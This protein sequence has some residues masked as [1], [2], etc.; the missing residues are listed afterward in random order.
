MCPLSQWF[1]PSH[2][3]L[4]FK[5]LTSLANGVELGIKE[6]F[7]APLQPLVADNIEAMQTFLGVLGAPPPPPPPP[8]LP[9]EV[10]GAAVA[11]ARGEGG[12]GAVGGGG[13]AHGGAEGGGGAEA[14]GE[15]AGAAG[16]AAGGEAG[17][18]AGG[19]E[20]EEEE[21]DPV[22]NEPALLAALALVQATTPPQPSF[23]WCASLRRSSQWCPPLPP[24]LQAVLVRTTT[25]VRLA[26]SDAA[27]VAPEMEELLRDSSQAETAT[28]AG[29]DG[30]GSLG[31]GSRK[32]K[33]APK[34]AVDEGALAK[35]MVSTAL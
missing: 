20:E 3:H 27:L 5:V 26:L 29:A 14:G 2:A 32:E 15:A 19:A 9:A 8:S 13:E 16:G 24:P 35:E 17:G 7:L 1:T 28:T 18:A 10:E 31:D 33:M 6:A 22:P 25:A 4:F 12:G 30:R 11:A 34:S 21:N 23:R